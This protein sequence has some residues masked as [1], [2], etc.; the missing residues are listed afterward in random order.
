[1]PIEKNPVGQPKKKK[2]G[3]PRIKRLPSQGERLV[4]ERKCS[5]CGGSGHNRASCKARI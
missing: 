3:R 4:L 5:A 2:L 1:M